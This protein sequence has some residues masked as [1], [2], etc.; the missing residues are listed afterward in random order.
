MIMKP[1]ALFAVFVPAALLAG[2]ATPARVSPVEVTR[3][4]APQATLG[5]GTISVKPGPGETPDSWDYSAFRSA[6]AT[7]LAKQGYTVSDSGQ[8]QALVTV[9]RSTE[10]PATQGRSPVSVGVGG[11]TGSF[12]SGV[13]MGVGINLGGN[14]SAEEIDTE[15]RVSIVPAGQ[16]DAI[17]EGRA[18]FSATTNSDFADRNAAASK[19][20]AALFAGFPGRSGETIEVE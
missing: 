14:K 4:S 13:G 18:R 7:E 20:A 19:L 2:C 11:S 17:W 10:R 12:G 3:F 5:S 15:L 9:R 6:V 1:L 16:A 8:Q